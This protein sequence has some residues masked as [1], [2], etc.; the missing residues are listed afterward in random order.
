MTERSE[1]SGTND[2]ER[3][4]RSERIDARRV[5]LILKFEYK[6][7]T[8]FLYIV[9]QTNERTMRVLIFDTETTGLPPKNTPTNHTDKWPHIVQLSWAIYNDETKQIEEENDFI[10]SLG[11][12]IHISPEST[13]IHGITSELSRA[14]GVPI[15]VALFDFKHAANRCGRM[16]AHNLEFDKNMLIVEY[17]RAR[18]FN[19][20]FPPSEYCT[21]KN[22]TQICKLVKTWEDGRTSFKYPK[23]IELYHTLYG[24]DVPSPE[25]LHNAKVDVDVCLKCYIKMM[26]IR[27]DITP[28]EASL[29]GRSII[30]NRGRT[31]FCDLKNTF[32]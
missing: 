17:Y 21:M 28:L 11:T 23:L 19:T 2:A 26:E 24:T 16:V 8:V 13:A 4:K 20:V 6:A 12:H 30:Y 14:R 5:K 25:G 31:R 7:I 10:I 18:L 1:A 29:N 27:D 9:R 32:Q 3:S 15:E 22:G